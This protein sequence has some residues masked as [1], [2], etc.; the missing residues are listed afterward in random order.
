MPT[1]FLNPGALRGHAARGVEERFPGVRAW[2]GHST[3]KYWAYIPP[4]RGGWGRLVE[5]DHPGRL[6]EL[7]AS[8]REAW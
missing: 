8:A 2:W 1:D 6:A 4:A 5:A 3:R 7:V